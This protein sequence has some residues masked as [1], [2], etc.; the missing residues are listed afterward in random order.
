MKKN[1]KRI[2]GMILAAGFL[3][4]GCSSSDDNNTSS[5]TSTNTPTTSESSSVPTEFVP[6]LEVSFGREGE[7][8][9]CLLY[10]SRCV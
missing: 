1:S 8:F 3:M 2:V 6:E 10:T 4:A 7:P 5:S 9:S